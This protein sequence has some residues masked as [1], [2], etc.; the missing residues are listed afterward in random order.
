MTREEL[1]EVF[2]QAKENKTDVYVAVTIPGQEDVEYIVNKH[3]SL[4]NK[5]EYYCKAYDENCVH[6][7][8]D[9]IRIVDAGMIDFY[10][11]E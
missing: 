11:G 3:R 6:V 7:T 1:K 4:E 8:N 2:A 9:Q 10:M 5:L